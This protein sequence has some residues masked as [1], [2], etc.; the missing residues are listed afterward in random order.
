MK[1]E[2]LVVKNVCA[3]K[4]SKNVKEIV[5][6][7]AE[8]TVNGL[9]LA[10]VAFAMRASSSTISQEHVNQNLQDLGALINKT[11]AKSETNA[12]THVHPTKLG[13]TLVLNAN[14]LLTSSS[15]VLW[16]FAFRNV[17]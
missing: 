7:P 13:Q 10:A 2:I 9:N 16:M 6:N 4:D 14:V 8:T 5:Y 12:L 1:R 3:N 15:V 11:T 17:V